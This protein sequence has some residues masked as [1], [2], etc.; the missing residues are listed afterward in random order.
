MPIIAFDPGETVGVCIMLDDGTPQA[1]E[2][3]KFPALVKFLKTIKAEKLDTVVIEKYIVFKGKAMAHTGTDLKTSQSVGQIKMWAEL[4]DL[5]V[6]EQTA[7]LLPMAE[8]R[9]QVKIPK[10]HSASHAICA[11]LHGAWYLMEQG[12]MLSALEK[13]YKDRQG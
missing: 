3:I 1:L 8:K 12:K 6:V 11:Y 13:E 5:P 9:T 2:Q 7:N 4:N 10:D